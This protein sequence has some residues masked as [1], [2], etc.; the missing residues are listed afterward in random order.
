MTTDN[1]KPSTVGDEPLETALEV[2]ARGWV[3]IDKIRAANAIRRKRRP[4]LGKLALTER[5][6]TM[7]QVFRILEE[8]AGTNEMFG[9]IAVRLE[10]LTEAE[11]AVLLSA[12]SAMTPPLADVLVDEG[13]ITLNQVA[14]IRARLAERVRLQ[15]EPSR[16]KGQLQAAGTAG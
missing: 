9:E 2:L 3:T 10:F 1:S 15:R 12:Q 4:V 8:Q 6:L 13:I 7:A 11:L 5:I 16:A 14:E